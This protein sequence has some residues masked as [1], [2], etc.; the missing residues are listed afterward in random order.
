MLDHFHRL[1]SHMEWADREILE[2]I[3]ECVP[4]PTDALEIFAHV[5]A[6]EHVWLARLRGTSTELAVWPALSMKECRRL[7]EENARGWREA[8]AA[9]DEAGCAREVSYRNSVGFDF[10]SRADDIVTHVMLH[11]AYHRGQIARA[12]RQEGAA[13]RPTDYIA[14][15]RGVPAA[16]RA[17]RSARP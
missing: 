15:V 14:F 12:F 3:E 10:V 1:V 2:A 9:M 5:L 17:A 16:T 6:A 13:P 8:A 11:G 7:A 4:P